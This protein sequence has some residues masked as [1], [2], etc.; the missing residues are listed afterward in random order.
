MPYTKILFKPGI[1]KEGTSLTAENGW[2]D[3][4]L[5]RFRRGLPEKV[6]GWTKNRCSR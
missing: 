1:D 2:F 6:G 5:I 3:G 4:N